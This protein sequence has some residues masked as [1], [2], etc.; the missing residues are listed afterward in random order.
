MYYFNGVQFNQLGSK[1][2]ASDAIGQARQGY[3]VS[4]DGLGSQLL[5]GGNNDNGKYFDLTNDDTMIFSFKQLF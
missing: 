5:F 2:V 1:I 4:L 3:S